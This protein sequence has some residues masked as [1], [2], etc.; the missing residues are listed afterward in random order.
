MKK[1]KNTAKY[2][3]HQAKKARKRKTNAEQKARSAGY[4]QGVLQKREKEMRD[5]MQFAEFMQSAR[6][7]QTGEGGFVPNFDDTS[8]TSQE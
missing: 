4:R 5:F 8:D 3:R 2:K 1:I 6:D 7:Q